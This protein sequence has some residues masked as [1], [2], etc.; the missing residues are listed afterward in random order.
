MEITIDKNELYSFIKRAVK[1]ALEEEALGLFLKNIPP[2]SQEEMEDIEKLYG[3]PSSK[4]E[5]VYSE[6]IEI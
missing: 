2:I 1:E 4:K 6:T 5:S 3:K